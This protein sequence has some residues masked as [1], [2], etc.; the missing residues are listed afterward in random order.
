M[1]ETLS[2]TQTEHSTRPSTTVNLGVVA[3]TLTTLWSLA[4]LV[5][6]ALW[7]SGILAA[8]FGNAEPGEFSSLLDHFAVPAG[9]GLVGFCA[10]S[11]LAFASTLLTLPRLRATAVVAVG[12]FGAILALITTVVFTDTL[13]LAYLGYTLS[14][15]F[16]P[17]PAA[18]LWQAFMLV[19]PGLWLVVW[20]SCETRRR[21]SRDKVRH[22]VPA[23][24]STSASTSAKTAVGVAVVVPLTYASTRIMWAIGIPFGLSDEFYT[25]GLKIGLWH[26]GLA[27]AIAG[28]VGALLTLGLVQKWGERFPRW[29]GPLA[30]R[31]VP[32]LLATI[33]ASIVTLALF[34]GGGGLVRA[35]LLGGIDLTDNWV[36][37]GPTLLFP[38]WALALGW[39]TYQYRARRLDASALRRG[40][41]GG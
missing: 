23:A 38:L 33:P 12:V 11:S 14:L 22:S 36:T 28:V 10:L 21:R 39:A 35:G 29:A 13:V 4:L 32:I 6:S 41:S 30:G 27:L 37:V 17:I 26:S 7:G 18:V 19:G 3:L 25:E 34:T 16:P 20:A 8:P 15:Q 5:V 40:G 24:V 1:K 31:R 9:A 2:N